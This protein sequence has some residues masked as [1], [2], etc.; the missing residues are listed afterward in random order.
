MKKNIFIIAI[1]SLVCSIASGQ[2]KIEPE[3]QLLLNSKNNE[4]ISINIIS[5]AQID[6]LTRIVGLGRARRCREPDGLDRANVPSL[7]LPR[8][9][10]SHPHPNPG[11][12]RSCRIRGTQAARLHPSRGG[13]K[14]LAPGAHGRGALIPYPSPRWGCCV[15]PSPPLPATSSPRFHPDP[16][17]GPPGV[18]GLQM[19]RLG[20]L[21]HT[22]P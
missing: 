22:V 9:P 17:L 20:S 1:I 19:P 3:L 15:H 4:M 2:V 11:L 16:G 10:H 14:R 6:S 8:T 13:R 21:G 5:K 18:W 7:S 12:A